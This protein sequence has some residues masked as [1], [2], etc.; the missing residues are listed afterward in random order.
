MLHGMGEGERSGCRRWN[1]LWIQRARTG[2]SGVER[3]VAVAS[4]YVVIAA[5]TAPA[6]LLARTDG[7][8]GP[9]QSC[10]QIGRSPLPLSDATPPRGLISSPT[11][12]LRDGR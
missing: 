1:M 11:P 10:L 4:S 5:S 2:R 9:G 8:P 3:R 7:Q 12:Y 6:L